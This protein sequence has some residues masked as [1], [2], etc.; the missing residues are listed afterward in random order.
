VRASFMSTVGAQVPLGTW[1]TNAFSMSHNKEK[2]RRERS[3]MSLEPF[4]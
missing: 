2:Q 3:Q 1:V 4:S